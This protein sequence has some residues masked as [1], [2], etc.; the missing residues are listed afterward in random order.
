MLRLGLRT[1]IDSPPKLLEHGGPHQHTDSGRIEQA[2]ICQVD[3]QPAASVEGRGRFNCR[4]HG[5]S[6]TDIDVA[7]QSKDD[8]LL[9]TFDRHGEVPVSRWRNCAGHG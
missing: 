5:R 6:G 7:A 9:V 2:D 4:Q 3:D 8:L 1:M